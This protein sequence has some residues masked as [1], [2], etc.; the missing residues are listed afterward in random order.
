MHSTE[1]EEKCK[2]I[3]EK[4]I[5]LEDQLQTA[6]CSCDEGFVHIL[7]QYLVFDVPGRVLCSMG[8]S[9]KL[10]AEESCINMV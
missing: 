3:S 8:T 10:H 1:L 4:L 9:V 5:H 7:F 2:K 6:A